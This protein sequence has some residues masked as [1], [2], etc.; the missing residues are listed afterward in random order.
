MLRRLALITSAAAMLALTGCSTTVALTP[1]DDANNPE[2]AEVTVRLPQSVA[3]QDRRWTDAQATGA[4]GSD[5]QTS[6]ILTCGVTVPGPTA[7]LQCVTLEGIDWLVDESDAPR[8]RMTTYGRD[9]AVQVFVDTEVVSANQV[10]TSPGIV[11]GVR[12][13]DAESACT[14]PDELPE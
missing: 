9:P 2:C 11:S 13:I 7:E 1:A 14:A 10:L 3:E 4:Y 6:V 8:M 12:M 5:G